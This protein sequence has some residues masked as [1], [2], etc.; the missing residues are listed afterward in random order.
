ML[1]LVEQVK[2]D[3]HLKFGFVVKSKGIQPMELTRELGV[4]YGHFSDVL[5]FKVRQLDAEVIKSFALLP[6]IKVLDLHDLVFGL[7]DHLENLLF[8]LIEKFHALN[9]LFLHILQIAD[10]LFDLALDQ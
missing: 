8:L 1:N 9:H 7:E 5:I 3:L 6:F 2:C 10:C 4:L